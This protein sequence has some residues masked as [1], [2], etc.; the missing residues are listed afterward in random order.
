MPFGQ[1]QRQG[2]QWEREKEE[3][4]DFQRKNPRLASPWEQ[5]DQH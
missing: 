1:Y 2:D 5:M 4:V 3:H